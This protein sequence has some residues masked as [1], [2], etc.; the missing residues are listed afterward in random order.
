MGLIDA[1]ADEEDG[2]D[3]GP[4][5]TP[6]DVVEVVVAF[7]TFPL[8]VGPLVAADTSALVILVARCTIEFA[9][10]GLDPVPPPP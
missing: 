7:V 4:D 9:L 5:R 8:I 2:E 6:G 3:A 10:F 1:D